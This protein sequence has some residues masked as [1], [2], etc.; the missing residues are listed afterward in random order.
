MRTA[1]SAEET[2]AAESGLRMASVRSAGRIAKRTAAASVTRPTST[3]SQK[4]GPGISA[5][6]PCMSTSRGII[7]T[8]RNAHRGVA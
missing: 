7:I 5:N 8:V 3:K 2:V 4:K 1:V 6:G